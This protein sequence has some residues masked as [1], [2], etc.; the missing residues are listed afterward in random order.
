MGAVLSFETGATRPPQDEVG[1]N[2]GAS[3]MLQFERDKL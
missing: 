1:I 2:A 3:L